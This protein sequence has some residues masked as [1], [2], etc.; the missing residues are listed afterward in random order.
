MPF[1]SSEHEERFNRLVDRDNT[2]LKDSERKALFF[3]FAGNDDL[4]SKVEALYDF[5]EHCI[6]AEGFDKVDLTSSARGLVELAFNLYN[7]YSHIEGKMKSVLDIFASL[8][9]DNFE[10]ALM[11]IRFRFNRIIM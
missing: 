2:H 7:N 9:E 4:Y 1:L 11:G 3:I 5:E 10:L 6:V 8:D